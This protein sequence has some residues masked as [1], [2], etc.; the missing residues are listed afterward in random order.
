MYPLGASPTG[1]FDLSGNV[2]EWQGNL[3]DKDHDVLALRGG[4]WG[5]NLGFARVAVRSSGVP[6]Y[7]WDF[8][9]GFRVV[10]FPS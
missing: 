5:G 6:Y 9:I 10:V 3:W 8:N 2:W 1:I 4:S 7:D